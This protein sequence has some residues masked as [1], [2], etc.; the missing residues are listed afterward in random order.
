MKQ[1]EY[2]DSNTRVKQLDSPYEER[3]FVNLRLSSGQHTVSSLK[4]ENQELYI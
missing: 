2:L 1:K 3:A 4:E